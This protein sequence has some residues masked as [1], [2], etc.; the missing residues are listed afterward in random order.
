MTILTSTIGKL[1]TAA[2]ANTRTSSSAAAT[3]TKSVRKYPIAIAIDIA[4]IIATAR[5]LADSSMIISIDICKRGHL[6]GRKR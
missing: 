6:E 5:I 1:I 4:I 2:V 3:A